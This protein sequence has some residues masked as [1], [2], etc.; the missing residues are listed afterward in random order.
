MSRIRLAVAH[1]L[2]RRWW[3]LP[4]ALVAAVLVVGLR[5]AT[6]PLSVGASVPDG[7]QDV[8]RTAAVEFGFNQDMNVQSVRQGIAIDP[9]V[10]F[11]VVASS[12]RRFLFKPDLQADTT[13]HVRLTGLQKALG[14]GSLSYAF[15]FHTEPA[16]K[17]TGLKLDETP[18]A[19]GQTA[20]PPRG[21]LAVTFSQPM[22][23]GRVPILVDGTA[24]DIA[25]VKWDSSGTTASFPITLF[26]SRPHT[27]SVPQQALNR[28]H[29]SLLADWKLG[30][31]TMIQVPSAGFTDRIGASNAPV[32]IQIEN[33]SQPTVRP[34]AG[35][36]LLYTS[37]SPRDLST[38][39][40]PSS[41]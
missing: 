34:Q 16:P 35:I 39:R 15:S 4:L 31:T 20:V 32:I 7:E 13:Y 33:S 2:R 12:P 19:D 8:A 38:T 11:T 40:M 5:A 17:V 10:L 6:A 30:F 29:D 1:R 26:H 23:G 27:V 21:T 18:L 14:F 22:D 24:V 25:T 41:A 9:A 28:K 36:C 3:L 37:P